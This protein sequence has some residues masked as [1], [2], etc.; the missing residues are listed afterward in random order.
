[1][2]QKLL[3]TLENLGLTENESKVYLA[4]LSLGPT[5]ILQIA[6]TTGILR[7]TV[8]P[9]VESLKN[10]GLMSIDV[11]EFKKKYRAQD[12]K[13]L[14]SVLDQK[15]EDLKKVFPEFET[16][17][18]LHGKDASLRY[19]EGLAGIRQVYMDSIDDCPRS[20]DEYLVITNQH[21]WYYL[22]EAFSK[23][24]IETRAKHVTHTR[25][26]S[27][28]S[29]IAREQKVRILPKGSELS[30]DVLITPK[31]LVIFQMQVPYIAIEIT[32]PSAIL[33]QKTLFN[34]IWEYAQ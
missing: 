14:D 21:D 4:A 3:K 17:Y 6:K 22:D 24:Y 25:L 9:T 1:M 7:T 8:Y 12:P 13:W 26:L 28:D 23:K 20:D 33:M 29:P 10:K 19:Y 30:T 5:S 16:L 27:T 32:N 15:K 34:I 11:G 2:N 31:R 18:N